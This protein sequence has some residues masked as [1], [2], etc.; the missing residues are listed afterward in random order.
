MSDTNLDWTL[1]N[2][3]ADDEASGMPG[4]EGPG[5]VPAP[6][7]PRPRWLLPALLGLGLL[8]A[9]SA[10]AWT[11]LGWARLQAQVTR[12]VV[13]ED[14]RSLAQ[15]VAAVQALQAAGEPAWLNQRAAE[16]A[17][18]LAAPLPAGS[19]LPTGAPPR[20]VG[21]RTAG[22][23][24]F[25]ATVVREYADSAGQRFEFELAQ[26]YH[27]LGPGLWERLP[28]VADGLANTTVFAS[29]HLS[30]TFPVADLPWLSEALPQFEATLARACLD[31]QCPPGL[32]VVVVFGARVDAAGSALRV[33]RSAAEAGPG[34][35]LIFDLP[36]ATLAH[37]YRLVSPRLTGYPRDARAAAA[38]TRATSAH[39]LAALAA[40]LAGT[41][42]RGPDFFL[43]AL[44]ARAERRLGLS[45]APAESITPFEY[46]SP[47][48][49]WNMAGQGELAAV[50]DSLSLRRQALGFVDFALAGQPPRVDGDL[51][52]A[53]RAHA[54][55]TNWLRGSL[56]KGAA[57]VQARW[58]AAALA[59]WS[60]APRA[61]YAGQVL[62][63]GPLALVVGAA[64]LQSISAR[65]Q[66]QRFIAAELSPDGR[67]LAAL[68][69]GRSSGKL[70]LFDLAE[71]TQ[72]PL[73]VSRPGVLLGWRPTGELL[74]LEVHPAN[75]R[76]TF[77]RLMRLRQYDPAH[78]GTFSTLLAEPVVLPWS[79]R[80][81]WSPD[82]RTLSLAVYPSGQSNDRPPALALVTPGAHTAVRTLPAPGYAPAFS[83]QGDRL[84]VFSG[85][86]FLG[87]TR[88]N[89]WRLNL[90]DLRQDQ[91]M[92]VLAAGEI[93]AAD[94]SQVGGLE[95]S[96]DGRWLTFLQVGA[97]GGP[98]AY[99]AAAGG[100]L[101]RPLAVGTRNGGSFPLGFSAD[102]RYL[103]VLVSG[104]AAG[105]NEIVVFD[106][107]AAPDAAPQRYLA[108]TAAWSAAG[109]QLLMGGA[110]GVFAV[111]PATDEFTWLYDSAC[112]V[113]FS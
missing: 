40:E 46:M 31:W 107:T 22:E 89:A 85:D 10:L 103:A 4:A 6:A 47:A 39:L 41:N 88:D 106:L 105:T 92:T 43:D 101:V 72:K 1:E 109:H 15:D 18:G 29:D 55:P 113:E 99:L 87:L 80:A 20:V 60:P 7:G 25:V 111:D 102:S 61:G 8:V 51:L 5:L 100:G 62:V 58:R 26:R 14:E 94:F 33:T 19:L 13:H 97:G 98:V 54:N 27:N 95:W 35:P 108:Q 75:G 59:S 36:P 79:Q 91:L 2:I 83:P 44:V 34:Y 66:G 65:P 49:L 86:P 93:D 63:C 73:P 96:A 76:S 84:A 104:G 67:T 24:R 77:W 82:R 110:A 3:P 57:D 81:V 28:P 12:E 74:Y 68:I 32:R 23:N 9:A 50:T 64:G 52:R 38:L 48:L 69:A 42:R 112:E 11:R 53:L 78:G 37:G 56:P 70:V 17:L 21:F 71:G 30:V 45:T 90:L 16:T